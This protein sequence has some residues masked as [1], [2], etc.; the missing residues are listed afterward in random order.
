MIEVNHRQPKRI[1]DTAVQ[2]PERISS[3]CD[4]HDRREQEHEQHNRILD[5]EPRLVLH[6]EPYR[7]K[8]RSG[9]AQSIWSRKLRPVSALKA[10][11]KFGLWR[12][13]SMTLTSRVRNP[14]ST[15]ATWARLFI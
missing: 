4:D 9:A 10:S 7:T 11:D 13:K 8:H 1:R 15:S 6:G 5:Q 14:C 2:T 3:D 12:L